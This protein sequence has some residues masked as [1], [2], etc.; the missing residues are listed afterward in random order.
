MPLVSYGRKICLGADLKMKKVLIL[1]EGQTEEQF[2][3]KY[4]AEY[5][6][7][8]QI[9]FYPTIINTKKILQGPNHKGGVTSYTQVKNDLI[10]LFNDTSANIITTMIDYFKLPDDFPGFTENPHRV[11]IDKV[12]YLEDAFSRDINKQRFIPNIMLHEFESLLFTE[13]DKLIS[14]LGNSQEVIS[15]VDEILNYYPNPEDINEGTDT[16]PSKRL[17][18]INLKYK[19]ILYSNYFFEEVPISKLRERCPHFNNWL[20]KIE[21]Y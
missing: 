7:T 12:L 11:P 1:V 17:E 20:S 8:K 2:I 16:A 13:R 21:E 5:Y 4:L 18:R 10:K 3:K 9:Y 6:I 15:S 19:K 14:I